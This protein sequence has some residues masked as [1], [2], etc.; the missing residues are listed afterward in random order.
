MSF[1]H[2]IQPSSV[3]VIFSEFKNGK[4][5]IINEEIKK[6]H[7]FLGFP[8]IHKTAGCGTLE[9]EG[10]CMSVIRRLYNAINR[11]MRKQ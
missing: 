10:S 5:V 1:I 9:A 2:T 3:L 4:W 6:V 8:N 11:T 7:I